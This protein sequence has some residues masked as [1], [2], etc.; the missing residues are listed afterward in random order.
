MDPVDFRA[1]E[2]EILLQCFRG[3]DGIGTS[4]R[5]LRRN[6]RAGQQAQRDCKGIQGFGH[7]HGAL[8][9]FA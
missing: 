6:R 7:R 2:T 4:G 5:R 3:I 8:I 9:K 1:Q